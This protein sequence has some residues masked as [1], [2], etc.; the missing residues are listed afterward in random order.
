V[1]VLPAHADH[2]GTKTPHSAETTQTTL[3]PDAKSFAHG[4]LTFTSPW[5]R[6]T[7]K[8]AKVGAGYLMIV[9]AGEDDTLIKASTDVSERVEI[10]EMKMVGDV[11]KMRELENGL[12]AII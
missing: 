12:V 6:A 1:L 2:D 5:A 4:Q 3:S 9:N 8:G 11:M 10:H 7:V